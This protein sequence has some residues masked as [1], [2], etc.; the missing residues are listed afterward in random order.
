MEAKKAIRHHDASRV[1]QALDKGAVVDGWESRGPL[2]SLGPDHG[3]YSAL[4]RGSLDYAF[5]WK[6]PAEVFGVLL[7]KGADPTN[8][9]S[10]PEAMKKRVG[11]FDAEAQSNGYS[12]WADK[13]GER[14]GDYRGCGRLGESAWLLAMPTP[15]SANS[16]SME[17]TVVPASPSGMAM[18]RARSLR[19][20]A[21]N[22]SLRA[23]M[24]E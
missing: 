7:E 8:F 17:S 11:F 20:T 16:F 5:H 18:A 22:P 3:G 14:V 19:T 23:S 4:T 6:A 9:P 1:R 13:H 2:L 15:T 10:T 21:S 12:K 24:A